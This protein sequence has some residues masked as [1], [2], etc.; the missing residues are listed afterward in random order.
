[1]AVKDL[2]TAQNI[3]QGVQND[4]KIVKPLEKNLAQYNIKFIWHDVRAMVTHPPVEAN[5][6]RRK[7]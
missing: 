3:F 2:Q 4:F 6:V 5:S 7:P 1:M